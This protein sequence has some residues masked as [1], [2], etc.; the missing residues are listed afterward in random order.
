MVTFNLICCCRIKEFGLEKQQYEWYLDLRRHGAVKSS[1]FSFSFDPLV[2]Y[3]TGL[4]D[5]KDAVPF[6][7]IIGK[8]NN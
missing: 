2:L 4:N 5:I 3:A 7:R 8:A 1:G 6:P